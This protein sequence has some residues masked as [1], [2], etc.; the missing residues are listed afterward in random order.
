M[1]IPINNWLDLS[2]AVNKKTFYILVVQ[3]IVSQNYFVE[4]IEEKLAK[5]AANC[6]KGHKAISS[7]VAQSGENLKYLELLN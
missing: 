7:K 5:N 4:T 3:S 6:F 2:E 1:F